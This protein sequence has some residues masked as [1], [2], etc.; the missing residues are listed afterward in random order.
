MPVARRRRGR[1]S[2]RREDSATRVPETVAGASRSASASRPLSRAVERS[3]ARLHEDLVIFWS[4]CG[5]RSSRAGSARRE[6]AFAA[7]QNASR[8]SRDLPPS[9]A[10]FSSRPTPCAPRGLAWLAARAVSS[11]RFSSLW[12]PV[13]HVHVRSGCLYSTYAAEAAGRGS[14]DVRAW[15]HDRA[16]AHHVSRTY[17]QAWTDLERIDAHNDT[18]VNVI[19]GGFAP[20]CRT[21]AFY[22]DRCVWQG[23]NTSGR[24]PTASANHRASPP[25]PCPARTCT[26][27]S[28]ASPRSTPRDLTEPSSTCS[29]ATARRALP[30][31]PGARPPRAPR[32][33]AASAAPHNM[34]T[35][36]GPR[37]WKREGSSRAPCCTWTFDT[38]ETNPTVRSSPGRVGRDAKRRGDRDVRLRRA[39]G[40]LAVA[41][42]APG[43]ALGARA[44]RRGVRE[45]GNRNPSWISQSWWRW[46]S[47]TPPRR[48][49]AHANAGRAPRIE[50]GPSSRRWS[51][52]G[53]S[54]SSA[55]FDGTSDE[56]VARCFE[57]IA[58]WYH[59]VIRDAGRVSTR[60]S[61]RRLSIGSPSPNTRTVRSWS[62][63]P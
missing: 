9:R 5:P 40:H 16:S 60:T 13:S 57:R 32:P 26:P 11:S 12:A 2:R 34:V 1:P 14:S 42:D 49:R 59:L 43:G 24:N 18:H 56:K 29:T 19:Y 20:K 10:S 21:G 17:S 63:S 35:I 27:S 38:T 33:R 39:L 48:R 47:E 23:A 36:H 44:K 52:R 51:S 62:C 37:P 30:T 53:R 28:P 6:D 4:V 7:A 15:L 41:R 45:T 58:L 3:H 22:G 54:T 61:R 55:C 8:V 31:S 46:C 25:P 50:R